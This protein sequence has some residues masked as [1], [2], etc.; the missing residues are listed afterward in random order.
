MFLINMPEIKRL[1]DGLD[2]A[3]S[4]RSDRLLEWM[5]RKL[6]RTLFRTLSKKLGL[7]SSIEERFADQG[8]EINI[9]P[10]LF[11]RI[12][13]GG[14]AYFQSPRLLDDGA[15]QKLRVRQE[16]VA[17]ARSIF[18][19][20]GL[21]KQKRLF[22]HIRRG[23]Y[24]YLPS[25]ERAVVLPGSWYRHQIQTL[26]DRFPGGHF[27]AL[28]D[29]IPYAREL[30]GNDSDVV[31]CSESAEVE[32]ALM[33]LCDGG[34]LSASSFSWWGAYFARRDSNA[35]VFVAPLYW[36]GHRAQRWEPDGIQTDWLIYAPVD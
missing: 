1:F 19:K 6:G 13:F 26:R 28:S 2:I 20:H 15:V 31:I 11:S 4:S 34:V 5:F 17:T 23:D 24:T 10:G 12:A 27:I 35:T 22:V 9:T 33:T 8:S 3:G 18:E 29:D 32:F 25:R 16:F 21:E 36:L 7:I 14:G 30:L